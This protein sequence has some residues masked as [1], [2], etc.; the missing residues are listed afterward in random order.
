ML[1][2]KLK[3]LILIYILFSVP[4]F[5]MSKN[6]R[7]FENE[8]IKFSV[9]S[10]SSIQFRDE[11]RDPNKIRII[12]KYIGRESICNTESYAFS[13]K[14][15]KILKQN[16]FEINREEIISMIEWNDI[17]KTGTFS[18]KP[19]YL[20]YPNG[21]RE[22]INY[23]T[24]S[25]EKLIYK[26]QAIGESFMYL[27]PIRCDIDPIYGSSIDCHINFVM[28]NN[29]VYITLT[30][31]WADFNSVRN[32]FP[33]FFEQHSDGKYYWKDNQAQVKFYEIFDSDEYVKLPE[34][35][36]L[37]KET[38]DMIINTLEIK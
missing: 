16:N 28:K 4:I 1:K 9:P 24:E 36:R 30:L 21:K 23:I 14:L 19:N 37:L 12:D 13:P 31:I 15:Y 29:L 18:L 38:R 35:I 33:E 7:I 8:F 22:Y 3:I 26:N 20:E 5:S 11:E 34:I 32:T 27:P 10:N 25:Y 6:V 17:T 2:N